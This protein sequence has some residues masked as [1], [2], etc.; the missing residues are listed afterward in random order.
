[1][2]Q[3]LSIINEFFKQNNGQY[4]K[5]WL[6]KISFKKQISFFNTFLKL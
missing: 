3:T 5:I 2:S 6:I 1:M 4:R